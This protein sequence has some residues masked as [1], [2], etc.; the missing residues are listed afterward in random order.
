LT[1]LAKNKD[2][3]AE[4]KAKVVTEEMEKDRKAESLKSFKQKMTQALDKKD[5]PENKN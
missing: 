3:L 1:E 2:Q 4:K 5:I